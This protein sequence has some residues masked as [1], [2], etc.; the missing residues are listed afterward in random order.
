MPKITAAF[1]SSGWFHVRVGVLVL[2]PHIESLPIPYT[3]VEFVEETV[4][5][6]AYKDWGSE[7]R[8]R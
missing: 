8:I 1:S 5:V 4:T 7:A 6:Y 3:Q 2:F